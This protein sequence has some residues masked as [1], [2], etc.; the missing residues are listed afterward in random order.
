MKVNLLAATLSVAVV[1]AVFASLRLLAVEPWAMPAFDLYAYWS[2]RD[3]FD[4]LTAHGI[5]A[6]RLVG[7]NGYGES[8]PIDTNDTK[9]GRQRNRRTELPVQK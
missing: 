4:Y 3:G 7:P 1:L 2:T 5:D 6:G 9:E 8:R